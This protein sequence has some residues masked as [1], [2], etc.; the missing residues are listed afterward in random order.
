VRVLITGAGGQLGQALVRAFDGRDVVAADRAALDVGDRDAVLGAITALQPDV[1]VHAGAWTDVDGCESDPDR[2]FRV[3]AMGTRHVMDGARRVGAHVVAISTDYVFDGDTDRP[4]VEWDACNPL[5]VYGRSKRAGEL[6]VD[7]S[8]AIVRTTWVF[9]RTAGLVPAILR[10]AKGRGELRFV[11]DQLACPT[12]V[13][14]LAPMVRDLSVSRR[15]GIFHVTNQGATTPLALARETLRL[16]GDDPDRV[17]PV[18][19]EELGRAARRPARSD[20]DNAALRLSGIAL[21][22]DHREPL[23]RLVKELIA[24]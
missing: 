10:L 6:E 20:L 19:T 3:N 15:P 4:Y 17:V 24:S 13:D 1:V 2:A 9:S 16:A 22:P 14:D 23:E 12:F 5:S 7:P 8:S 21:L 18:T 11:D